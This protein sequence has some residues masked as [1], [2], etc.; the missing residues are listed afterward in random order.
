M[1]MM[2]M[3][4]LKDKQFLGCMK[5]TRNSLDICRKPSEAQTFKI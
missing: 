4:C 3:G 1:M 5:K 2:M